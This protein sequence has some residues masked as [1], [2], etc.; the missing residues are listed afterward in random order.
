MLGQEGESWWEGAH[1]ECCRD[2]KV[3]NSSRHSETVNS[4]CLCVTVERKHT[5]KKRKEMKRLWTNETKYFSAFFC[6]GAFK[7]R[8]TSDFRAV[9]CGKSFLK[10]ALV[11]Y[12]DATYRTFKDVIL[13]N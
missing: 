5:Q 3:I 1:D 10:S 2:E 12:H 11:F 9:Q 4:V 8:V 13:Y 6:S 7:R